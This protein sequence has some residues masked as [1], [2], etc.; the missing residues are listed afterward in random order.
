[1]S[2]LFIILMQA[3]K[4]KFYLL[5]RI[6]DLELKTWNRSA[7]LT[8]Y[9]NRFFIHSVSCA[10]DCGGR[11]WCHWRLSHFSLWIIK[12]FI[13]FYWLLTLS[14]H[15]T[16]RSFCMGISM[17]LWK[18]NLGFLNLH[19]RFFIFIFAVLRKVLTGQKSFISTS[20]LWPEYFQ[21]KLCGHK[22]QWIQLFQAIL[23][24]FYNIRDHA[25]VDDLETNGRNTTS[26]NIIKF[27]RFFELFSAGEYDWQIR[28]QKN[29][30]SEMKSW[31]E[32]PYHWKGLLNSYISV[33]F[34]IL[35]NNR[36]LDLW[37][38]QAP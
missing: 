31:F 13:K 30:Q 7:W 5:N 6:R 23:L 3:T 1:M 37:L 25:S 2:S 26:F 17:E 28:T 14:L 19:I 8:R 10:P 32:M 4:L 27:I 18:E 12:S 16:D 29:K 21:D 34:D 9:H 33:A 11:Y 35:S 22:Q 36:F 20:R 38:R 15:S 24:W